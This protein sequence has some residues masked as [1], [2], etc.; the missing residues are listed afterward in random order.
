MALSQAVKDSIN[1]E[2]TQRKISQR[3]LARRM[4]LKQQYVWRRLSA[5]VRADMEW[6]PSELERVAEAIGIPV[7]RLLRIPAR[8]R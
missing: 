3:E 1:A 5:N 2:M 6:T 8:V 7:S 4:G